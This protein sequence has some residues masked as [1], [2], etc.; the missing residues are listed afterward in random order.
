MEVKLAAE[1]S[2]TRPLEKLDRAKR[3]KISMT[4]ALWLSSTGFE[5]YSRFDVAVVRGK[6]GG[7]T[8]EIFENAFPA[9][10]RFSI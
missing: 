9:E 5:G 8:V 6:P 2:A 3:R 1:G 7:F 4:A 10:G